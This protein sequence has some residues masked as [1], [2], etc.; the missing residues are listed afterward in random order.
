MTFSLA[1]LNV[2]FNIFVNGSLIGIFLWIHLEIGLL[3]SSY[4]THKTWR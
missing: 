1:Y 2:N 4:N 3:Q